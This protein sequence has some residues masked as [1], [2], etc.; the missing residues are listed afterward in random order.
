MFN[1]NT[2]AGIAKKNMKELFGGFSAQ[3]RAFASD[4]HEARLDRRDGDLGAALLA[5]QEEQAV[6]LGQDGVG[7][8]TRVAC[9][10]L[11]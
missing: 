1:G 11:A 5:L 7:G 4:G 8:L 10:V 9:H 3:G 2:A 6:L